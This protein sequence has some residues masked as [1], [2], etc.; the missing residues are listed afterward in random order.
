MAIISESSNI[1]DFSGPQVVDVKEELKHPDQ[2]NELIIKLV[3]KTLEKPLPL[4]YLGVPQGL[5]DLTERAQSRPGWKEC[6]N[7]DPFLDELVRTLMHPEKNSLIL[8][9]KPG[10]GKTHLVE[11]L[12]YLIDS[13]TVPPKY[14]YL[15]NYRIF[16][17]DHGQI[18]K[19]A[20]LRGGY[21]QNLQKV[22]E[23]LAKHP[24]IICFIDETHMLI[25]QGTAGHGEADA[26]NYLKEALARGQ[27]RLIGATTPGEFRRLSGDPAF[28]RRWKIHLIQEPTVQDCIKVLQVKREYLQNHYKLKEITQE[29]IEYAVKTAATHKG[30]RSLTDLAYDLLCEAC[31]EAVLTDNSTCNVEHIKK[32]VPKVL[33]YL[34]V[35]SL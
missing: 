8:V 17:F 33:K 35:L 22:I 5:T 32:S 12:A 31:A 11:H 16:K 10:A 6:A 7:R 1:S 27:V 30:A 14:K 15:E 29:V 25:G 18:M 9:G 28:M 24:E 21:E 2:K 34:K 20:D 23:Y 13:N 19:G 26:A 3:D 4:F